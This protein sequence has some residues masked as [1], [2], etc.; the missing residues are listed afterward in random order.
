MARILIVEDEP[1]MRKILA[2]NLR[3]DGHIPLELG[4]LREA[5]A[6]LQAN[7]FDVILTDQKLP[8]GKGLDIVVAVT[9]SE[10]SAA[11][12]MLTAYGSVELA[13]DAMRRGAY[14]FLTK[15]FSAE[16]LKAVIQRAA[17]HTLLRREND[18]LRSAV[19]TLEGKSEIR[20]Q[21]TGIKDVRSMIERV[22]PTDATVL[23]TGET[24]TGKELVARAIHK[25]SSRAQ[26]PI[27]SV[28]CAAF[29]DS[30]LESEL[31]GH[32]K[33][34]FT[35]ADRLRHGLF[36]T[37]HEGTLFLDEAGE[38][39]PAAQA[40]LLRVL[41]EGKITRV[42]SSTARDVDVRVLVATHRNLL[43]E[44][45]EG[46]FR[47]DLYYRLAIVPI[48]VPPL[49][50]RLDDIPEI[51]DY[52]LGQIAGE[53][54][55]SRRTLHP[56]ALAQLQSY[57]YPGNIRELRNLL[58]RACILTGEREIAWI[59]LPEVE[60]EQS[61]AASSLPSIAGLALPEEFQLRT[62]LAN[63]ERSMIE[64]MLVKTQGSKTEAARRLGLSKSDLSYRLSKY[65]LM[66]N[67]PR[68]TGE[69]SVGNFALS[70]IPTNS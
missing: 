1:N 18:L 68:T 43:R 44:V 14:D 27:V 64:Q 23:I 25:A 58:E 54:K 40:K 15:P 26:K 12:V 53:L 38:M 65:G 36:E 46:R 13:V 49:R 51:A 4:T 56:D 55:I 22:G 59:D 62:I 20:G 39:S 17:R 35:G 70:Q 8:D 50:A 10:S 3:A 32:E 28:N 16:N 6:A 41:A 66:R 33:G 60:D 63:W 37:A 31:F 45:E 11:V 2:M 61:G 9:E 47:R 69:E 29:P 48:E 5:L 52:L 57:H 24:G 30:L 42:G 19:G 34:A 7:D 21:S 67:A